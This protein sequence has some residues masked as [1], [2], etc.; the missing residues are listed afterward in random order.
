[1]NC[2]RL[3]AVPSNRIDK[4]EPSWFQ[5]LNE[6]L[7]YA[8]THPRGDGLT[9]F[10]DAGGSLRT[11]GAEDAASAG[12]DTVPEYIGPFR[13]TLADGVLKCSGGWLNRNGI[14]MDDLSE[15]VCTELKEGTVA[16]RSELRDKVWSAPALVIVSAPDRWC[17]PIGKLTPGEEPGTF[18]VTQYPVC[19]AFIMA[20]EICAMSKIAVE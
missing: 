9:I 2:P 4:I 19:C 20:S 17:Y 14:S 10:N 3:P 16:I 8:M 7:E 5:T 12:K 13:L 6:C 18:E 11:S 15:M 1:M